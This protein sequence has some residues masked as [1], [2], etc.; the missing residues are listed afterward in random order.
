MKWAFSSLF[1]F[2]IFAKTG[3]TGFM[4]QNSIKERVRALVL[5]LLEQKGRELVD[6]E[7]KHEGRDWV[8][9]LFIDQPGGI[10]L[11]DCVE[12]SREVSVILEVED[13]IESGYRLEVS[14]P[15]IER[16][17]TKLADFER[18]AGCLAKVKSRVLIDPE[19]RGR[20]RKTFVGT[21][22][23]LRDD[24]VVMELADKTGTR[25]EIPFADIE[26]AN[27]EIDF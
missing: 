16:P 27:L 1:L 5:P 19:G 7:F 22:R 23:G 10:T 9:R 14:S 6:L 15:G 17:L 8:L 12:V 21:L 24:R 2:S 13:P 3:S 25:L 18:F 26:K 4:G 20:G 11:D